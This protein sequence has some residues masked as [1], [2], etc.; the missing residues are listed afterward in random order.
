MKKKTEPVKR[1]SKL[2][3]CQVRG[4]TFNKKVPGV[5]KHGSQL[6]WVSISVEGLHDWA[7]GISPVANVMDR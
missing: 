1:T 6:A 7:T 4:K 3:A 2:H 5:I